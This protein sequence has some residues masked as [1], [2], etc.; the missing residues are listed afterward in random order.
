MLLFEKVTIYL[1]SMFN[2]LH[3]QMYVVIILNMLLQLHKVLSDSLK[4]RQS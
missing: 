2:Y 4:G 1:F 3:V